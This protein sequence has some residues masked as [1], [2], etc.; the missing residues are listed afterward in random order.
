MLNHFCKK[1]LWEVSQTLVA[2]AGGT[3]P[4]DTV[5][6]GGKLVNV[7]TAE[8]LEDID[9]A[10]SEGRIAMP[11]HVSAKA[12]RLLMPKANIWHR[13]SWTVIFTSNPLC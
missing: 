8:I 6:R 9:I 11:M 7:C 12:P 10:I 1:P 2:V 13:A 4:A 5:I 3:K